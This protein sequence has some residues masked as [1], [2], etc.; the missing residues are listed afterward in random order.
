MNHKDVMTYHPLTKVLH[1]LV[2]ILVV[3]LLIVGFLLEDLPS[4]AYTLHKSFGLIVLVLMLTRLFWIHH[5][6]RPALPESTPVWEWFFARAVQ[7]SFYLVLIAMPMVGWIMATASGH[8]PQFLGLFPLPFPGIS[9]DKVLA[10]WMKEAHELLAWV[11][12]GLLFF[13]IAGALK[14]HFWNKDDVLRKMWF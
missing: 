6:G 13:H 7:Y 12:I 5:V 1:W 14:H 9:E 4:V 3:T 11:I 2:A 10:D 8:A